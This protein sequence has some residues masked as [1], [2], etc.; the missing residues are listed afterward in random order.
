MIDSSQT[1]QLLRLVATVT[2]VLWMAALLFVQALVI[3]VPTVPTIDS[4]THLPLTN[5]SRVIR[6]QLGKPLS[7]PRE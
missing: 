6:D 7:P 1:P 3:I 5:L 4:A 2:I